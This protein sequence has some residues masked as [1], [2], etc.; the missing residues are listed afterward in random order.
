[1]VYV[2]QHHCQGQ[3]HAFESPVVLP[4]VYSV[5]VFIDPIRRNMAAA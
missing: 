4:A 3:C 5:F 2:M 1:M